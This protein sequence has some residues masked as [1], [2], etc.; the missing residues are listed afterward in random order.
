ML[1]NFR[2]PLIVIAPKTLLRLSAATS[3]LS[4]MSP[5]TTFQ[6]VL[7]DPIAKTNSKQV[8]RL[9]FVTGKHFY[10]LDEKRTE[11][12]RNDVAIIRLESLCPFPVQELQQI[13]NNYTNATEVI[14]SQ[15]EHRNNGAWSFIKPRFENFLGRQVRNEKLYMLT[16]RKT[17]NLIQ[18]C[19]HTL[20][21][22]NINGNI[23]IISSLLNIENTCVLQIKYKGRGVL[24]TPA[25][26]VG[27]VHRAEVEQVLNSTFN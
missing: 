19:L 16:M 5:G 9:I 3:S 13:L 18:D 1:R 22:Y 4:D 10:A 24:A 23:I 20:I 25:V 7:D 21:Y 15:E 2:K 14:W 27:R 11:L 26:G 17:E 6:P 12:K 8:K